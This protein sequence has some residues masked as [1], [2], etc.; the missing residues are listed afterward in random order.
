MSSRSCEAGLLNKGEPLY[1]V[2]KLCLHRVSFVKVN[3]R[4]GF[5]LGLRLCPGSKCPRFAELAYHR[6]T[7]EGNRDW[8]VF[9]VDA[10]ATHAA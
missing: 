7:D 8:H 6:L 3:W 2:Y 10:A 4:S 5:I 1:H 9:D